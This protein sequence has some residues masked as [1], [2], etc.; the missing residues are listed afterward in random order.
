MATYKCE[1]CGLIAYDRSQKCMGCGNSDYIDVEKNALTLADVLMFIMHVDSP[2]LY[3]LDKTKAYIAD[4]APHM[5]REIALIEN[6]FRSGAIDAIRRSYSLLDAALLAADKMRTFYIS[7]QGIEILLSAYENV[8]MVYREAQKSGSIANLPN[9]VEGQN[10]NVDAQKNGVMA[11]PASVINRVA[12]G[13]ETSARQESMSA[14]AEDEGQDIFKKA[15]LSCYQLQKIG[16]DWFDDL[17]RSGFTTTAKI[18]Q[19]WLKIEE[20]RKAEYSSL[21]PTVFE[22]NK[23]ERSYRDVIYNLS[24]ILPM[25]SGANLKRANDCKDLAYFMLLAW[26]LRWCNG[27]TTAPGKVRAYLNGIILDCYKNISSEQIKQ[28]A[29]TMLERIK[30]DEGFLIKDVYDRAYFDRQYEAITNDLAG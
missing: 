22:I 23:A 9:A 24:S 27:S 19:C 4:I 8:G 7:E 5:N 1:S 13:S 11:E 25:A 28:N 26:S 21:Y 30:Q 10:K 17:S 18:D 20:G 6:A 15:V 3:D 12:Q 14:N 16:S 2:A 29:L